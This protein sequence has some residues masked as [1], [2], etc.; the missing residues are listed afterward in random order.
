MLILKIII[1]IAIFTSSSY[2]GILFSRKYTNRVNE[3]KDFK[4][5]F[6]IFKTK[7][8][9]TYAPLDEIFMDIS[10]SVRGTVG[11]TFLDIC[12]NMKLQNATDSFNNAIDTVNLDLTVE[13]KETIKNLSKLLGKTDIE[14]Q[15]SQIDLTLSFLNIQIEK[16][17]KEKEKNEKLYKTLGIITGLGIVII[18]M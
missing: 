13:D 9:Y 1:Y 10:K 18:L 6:N 11:L 4:N 2:V 8:K 12:N 17:E 3:L 7:L 5:A 15:L 14:G 16:A